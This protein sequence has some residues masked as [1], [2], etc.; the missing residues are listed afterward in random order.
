[1]G[2]YIYLCIYIWGAIWGEAARV[3]RF[4]L[5]NIVSYLG[6]LVL[7]ARA[8]RHDEDVKYSESNAT[9]VPMRPAWG[10][11]GSIKKQS[12]MATPVIG[13]L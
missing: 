13:D 12:I 3:T 8:Q 6:A 5:G 10:V 9:L 2:R 11:G 7:N 1:M 4:L